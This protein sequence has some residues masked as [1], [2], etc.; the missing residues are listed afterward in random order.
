MSENKISTWHDHK[1]NV[2]H[3][4]WRNNL[5]YEIE[6]YSKQSISKP[7]LMH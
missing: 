6:N 5:M 3:E 2:M 4:T 1:S 7:K